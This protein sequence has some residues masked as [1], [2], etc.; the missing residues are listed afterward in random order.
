MDV[1]LLLMFL[2]QKNNRFI[3]ITFIFNI[4]HFHFVANDSLGGG[5][6]VIQLHIIF[7]LYVSAKPPYA[8]VQE[9]PGVGV[10]YREYTHDF[11]SSELG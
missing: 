9:D 4:V 7:R 5:L 10:G 6:F 8:Y 11:P 1:F 3:N 2:R